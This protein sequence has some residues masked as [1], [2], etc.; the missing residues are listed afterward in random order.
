VVGRLLSIGEGMVPAALVA[1]SR[2]MTS[3]VAVGPGARRGDPCSYVEDAARAREKWKA[4]AEL[5]MREAAAPG[6]V[7]SWDYVEMNDEQCADGLR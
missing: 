1:S 6:Y 2:A 7:G 5:V 3:V 4:T